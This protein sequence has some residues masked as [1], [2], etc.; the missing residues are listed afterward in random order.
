M[1][2][3]RGSWKIWSTVACSTTRPRYITATSVAISATTPR[4]WVMSMIAIPSSR[5]SWRRSS[6]I[7][8][9]VVTS[10]AVVGS[11]AI[12]SVGWQDSAIAIIAR[13]RSPPLSWL[14]SWSTRCSGDDT[15]TRRSIS[16]VFSRASRRLTCWWS[17]IASTI[18][19]PTVCTGL[20]EDMGSWKMSAISAPRIARISGPFG[21]SFARSTTGSA[22]PA[23]AWRRNRIS[24]PTIRP[25]RSTIPRIDRAVTLLP[26]PLSPT[27][28]S[29]A[30]GVQVEAH[31]V[32]RLHRAL[33]LGEVGLQVPDRQ[34]GL[35]SCCRR[36]PASPAQSWEARGARGPSM[37]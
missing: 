14:E 33:V 1:Y 11:S 31:P 16:I 26:Q 35:A 8:V 22:A 6:R 5:W 7:W 13:W 9:C 23:A 19:L 4:S 36:A 24:P 10:S 32:D 30:P 28:P 25:G 34:H 20:N 15:P 12:S 3:C 37:S 17:M 21:A 18:W 27:M 29:V 2:G